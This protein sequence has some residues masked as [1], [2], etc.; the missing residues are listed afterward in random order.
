MLWKSSLLSLRES[1]IVKLRYFI[2]LSAAEI[3]VTLGVSV[4]QWSV[5]A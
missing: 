3:A 4:P 2:G 5:T 1:E